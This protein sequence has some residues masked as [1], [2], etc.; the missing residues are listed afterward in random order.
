M[1]EEI[2]QYPLKL[3]AGLMDKARESS[4]KEDIPFNQWLRNAIK[5]YLK[6]K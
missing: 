6:I 4:E 3:K 1:S 5:K 2:K